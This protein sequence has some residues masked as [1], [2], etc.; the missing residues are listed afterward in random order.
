MRKKLGATFLARFNSG[1]GLYLQTE[2]K[3][4]FK[5]GLPDLTGTKFRSSPAYRDFI[6]E[7]GATPIVMPIS[8]IYTAL[9]RGVVEGVGG[10]LDSV[11]QF[12]LHKFLKYWIEP[13][14][15]QAGIIV[16]ANA[17]KWDHLP[18]KVR[19][20]LN[21]ELRAYEKITMDAIELRDKAVKGFM[22]KHGMQTIELK[23]DGP[24][25][26]SRPT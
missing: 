15:D 16:I 9:E 5:N 22:R 17:N 10:D 14:F 6:K 8:Q 12:G 1:L 13:P 24:S 25:T 20:L 18:P 26:T 4:T 3:P 2:K 7:L 19:D 11:Q 21:T 23:G